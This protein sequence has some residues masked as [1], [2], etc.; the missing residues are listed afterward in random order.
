MRN[1]TFDIRTPNDNGFS[2]NPTGSV[3]IYAKS[4]MKAKNRLEEEGGALFTPI[5]RKHAPNFAIGDKLMELVST[6]RDA[7]AKM[8]AILE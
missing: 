5:E 4:F 7:A 8:V 2:K 1:Y 3:T 6:D